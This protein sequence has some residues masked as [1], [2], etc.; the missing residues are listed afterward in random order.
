MVIK[1]YFT[2]TI[3]VIFLEGIFV[4]ILDIVY[5]PFS[6]IIVMKNNNNGYYVIEYLE[7]LMNCSPVSV[8]YNLMT[9]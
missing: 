2:Y 3:E 7:T 6:E 1:F 5:Q 8:I 9:L 4:Q